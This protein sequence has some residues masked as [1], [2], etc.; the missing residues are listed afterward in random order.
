MKPYGLDAVVRL[1]SAEPPVPPGGHG[2]GTRPG[3][4]RREAPPLPA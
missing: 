2:V 3:P 1:P 4:R